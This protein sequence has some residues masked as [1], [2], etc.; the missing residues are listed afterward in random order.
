[1]K[2][3]SEMLK[4]FYDTQFDCEIAEKQA[5]EAKEKV[6]AKAKVLAEHRASRVKEIENVYKKLLDAQGI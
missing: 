3:Y 5:I 1:M 2:F 4:K 6:E